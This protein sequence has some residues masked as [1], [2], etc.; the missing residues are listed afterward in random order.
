MDAVNSSILTF[1]FSA[2]LIVDLLQCFD[3]KSYN[4]NNINLNTNLDYQHGKLVNYDNQDG[5]NNLK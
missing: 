5:W 3:W 2:Y 1:N 4:F